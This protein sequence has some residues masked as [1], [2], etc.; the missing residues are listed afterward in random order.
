MSKRKPGSK[1]THVFVKSVTDPGRHSDGPGGHGLSLLVKK[2]SKHGQSKSWV[3]R[4][5]INGEDH[6]LG[7][8]SFPFVLLAEAREKSFDNHRRVAKGEDIMK[9]PPTI[10][11]VE[12]AFEELI[13]ARA[14]S[15]EGKYTE[16]G[17]HRLLGFCKNIRSTP[18]SEVT[19]DEVIKILAP[20]WHAKA[21]TARDLR[22]SLSAVME[23]AIRKGHRVLANPVPVK[24]EVTR[25]LGKQPPSVHYKSLNHRQLGGALATVRDDDTWWAAKYCIIFIA[26]TCVRSGE[27]RLATWDEIDW[28]THTWT[29]PANR[30]KKRIEHQVPL[31]TQAIRILTHARE[32]SGR[33]EG[34]IFPPE[35]GGHSI[36]N[37]RL[38][39]ILKRL[40]LPFVPHG[41]RASFANWAG[42]SNQIAQPV[43]GMV[44]AHKQ[45][46]EIEQFYMTDDFFEHREPVMQNWANFLSETMG[47]VISKMPTQTEVRTKAQ[48][49]QIQVDSIT[50]TEY[51]L[52]V[53]NILQSRPQGAPDQDT[54][55]GAADIGAI[56]LMRDCLLRPKHAAAARWPDLKREK[57][58]SGRLTIPS[59]TDGSSYVSARTM[60]ALDEMRSMK[61]ELG[62]DATDNRILQMNE[63][64]LR[65]HIQKACRAAGLKG[66]FGA[67]SP[68][69]GMANDLVRSGAGIVDLR[70]AKRWKVPASTDHSRRKSLA[71]EGA[72]AEWYADKEK[73]ALAE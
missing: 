66:N 40:G 39:K 69:D 30:M 12:E 8:G 33:S 34:I 20:L 16:Y 23:R 45:A 7:L 42:P 11:T 59:E 21:K 35:R 37:G 13:T 43:S 60:A 27:A 31:S 5:R 73:K 67:F 55:R 47:P 14:D 49:A 51:E 44:L 71:E 56:A 64:Q 17:W 62:M 19:E 9:P 61:R 26:L 28:D 58:G 2:R 24:K 65:R 48:S 52:I 46:P 25:S 53:Q 15:W 50:E 41:L 10:P 72:V 63:R 32:R 6:E 18:V 3:Q 38:S 68:R 70:R 29:I 4:I 22:F 36:D 54:L 57:D 1:L